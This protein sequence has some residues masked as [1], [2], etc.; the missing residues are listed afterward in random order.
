LPGES[1]NLLAYSEYNDDDYDQSSV[2][3][4]TTSAPLNNPPSLH[5]LTYQPDSTDDFAANP[6]DAPLGSTEVSI[7]LEV[8]KKYSHKPFSRQEQSM[9]IF[10]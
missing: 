8:A 9:D 4:F 5:D 6:H 2:D 3:M 7:E 10:L 1:P